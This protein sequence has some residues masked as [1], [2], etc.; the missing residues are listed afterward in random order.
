[1]K[2]I[3]NYLHVPVMLTEAVTALNIKPDGVYLDC[4]FGRGGHST[5]ILDKLNSKGKLLVIDLDPDAITIAK[6]LQK[7]DPRVTV[8]HKSFDEVIQICKEAAI[9]KLDGVL[10]DLGVSS[11]QLED[12]NRGFSFSHDGPLDM[13]MDHSKGE[14]AYKWLQ[15]ASKEDITQV[16][17]E[18]GQ[19][20]FASKIANAIVNIRD[21]KPVTTT[22]ALVDIIK[23]N[24]PKDQLY[25]FKHPATRTFQAIRIFINKELLHL[26]R[27]L[28][29]FIELL[30]I[31][32]RLVVISFHS[33]EDII[34]KN[35]INKYSVSELSKNYSIRKFPIINNNTAN[36]K[37]K[38][39]GK[40]K[41]SIFEINNNNRS[42]SAI[43]R[44]AEKC[45]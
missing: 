21:I 14:P 32:G 18:Y 41:P 39:L 35:F 42:R 15:F 34:V 9:L 37:L 23:K 7:L 27:A 16:L 22:F 1:M 38:N 25:K 19:E 40:I 2:N 26:D 45:A 13:R 3:I 29:Q 8:F 30:N 44:V 36:I 5:A 12:F 33:L 4:T 20:R 10:L 24:Y 17:K 28:P 43:M 11:P 31:Y 6:Q